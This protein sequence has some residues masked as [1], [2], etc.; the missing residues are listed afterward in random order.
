MTD[1][2]SHL[3]PYM[4]YLIPVPILAPAVAAALTLVLARFMQMQRLVAFFSL[5][6][7]ITVSALMLVVIDQEGSQ[8]LQI[9]GWDSPVGITLVADRLSTLMLSVSGLVLFAVMWYAIAQG[10]RDGGEDEPV[11]VF[12]PT[13]LLLS[14]GV[15]ISFLAGDLFNLYVG[16]EVFLV[17]SYVLLTLG[18]SAPRVRAGVGYVMVSM[19]SSMIF[20]FGLAMVYAAVGTLNMAQIGMRMEDVPSGTRA[21]IF[22]VLLVAFGIKAAVFPLD[23][24]L[25]DS[26]PTAPS[27]V[28]AVFAGLLTKVGVYS[29]IR[30]QTVIFTDGSLNTLLLVVALATMFVGILGAMAQSDIKRLLSFTLV[31]HI[32]YMIFGLALGTAHGLSGAIFYAVHHILV[33]TALFLVV[34]LIERQAGTSSLRRLGSLLY[35]T[36]LIAILYFIPAINLGGIPPFSGFIGKIMLM[37]AGAERGDAMA[38]LL[39]G[40]AVITSLLTLYVMVIVWSKGFWRDRKDAP[41]GHLAIARPA[42]LADVTDEVEMTERDDVG[43]IPVGMVGS[44]TLLVVASLALTVFAGPLVGV[45]QRAAESAS[46][47]SIYRSAVLGPNADDPTRTLDPSVRLDEGRDSYESRTAS[48]TEMTTAPAL[49]TDAP[50]A[51]STD[52]TAAALAS[53]TDPT[54]EEER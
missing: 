11:A 40:G 42:P 31:S 22:A 8:T 3:A 35:A 38:W 12:V 24:W 33:Q 21:A 2:A 25:P 39:I 6:G 51:A 43:R 9:G 50:A 4:P 48:S 37:Q 29:I 5:L 45:A 28:T 20:L 36:P 18:G 54:P 52:S 34:G 53:A 32:G 49:T 19:V 15:N 27:L 26:Y 10:V 17:A 30:A 16:F 46:D 47:V 13:Y 41:E 14:M 7:T 44:T 23:A 1:L